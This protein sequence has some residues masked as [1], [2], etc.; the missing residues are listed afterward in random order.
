MGPQLFP[1]ATSIIPLLKTE[2]YMLRTRGKN[3]KDATIIIRAH[4]DAQ[5][6]MVQNVIKV[7]QEVGFE[8]F[9]LR[10]KTDTGF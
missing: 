9:T 10:A 8:K 5:T 3:E 1:D 6:G 7:C 4:R 2:Q